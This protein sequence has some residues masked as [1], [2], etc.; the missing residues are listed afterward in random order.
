MV[1]GDPEM[2]R[3][4]KIEWLKNASNEELVKQFERSSRAAD[5][6]FELSRRWGRSIDELLEDYELSKAELMKR[7]VR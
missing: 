5:D 6:V 1:K 3:E 4:Q 7:M 2:T